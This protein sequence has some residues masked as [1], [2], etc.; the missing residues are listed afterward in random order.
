[1]PSPGRQAFAL[2]VRIRPA[3]TSAMVAARDSN[4]LH[5]VGS[6]VRGARDEISQVAL[7]FLRGVISFLR[8]FMDRCEFNCVALWVRGRERVVQRERDC[9]VSQGETCKSELASVCFCVCV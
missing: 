5:D 3:S 1:M 8:I 6:S 9:V 2:V 4:E 7:S